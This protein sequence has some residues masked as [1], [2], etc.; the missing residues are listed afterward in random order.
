MTTKISTKD[1]PRDEWLAYRQKSLGGSDAAALLGLS[2]Y[3]SPYSLWAEKTGK[4]IPEDISDRE[5]VRLGNDLEDYVAKRFTEA[6]GK[7]VRRENSI[8]YNPEM[9][10]AHANI[11][12]AVIGEEAG[13]ECKTTISNAIA[14]E[15][16]EGKVPARFYCQVVH[17]LMI[18]GWKRFYLGVL[19]FGRGFYHFVIERDEAEIS[20]LKAAEESFWQKVTTNTP[21]DV[22][23][24]EA[25]L[26]A[27]R[28]IQ[29][30]SRPGMEISLMGVAGELATLAALKKREAELAAEIAEQQARIMG[31]MGGAERGQWGQYKISY[32]TQERRTFDRARF[33]ADHGKIP[34][35]YYKV[36]TSRPLKLSEVKP[37]Q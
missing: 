33:E 22:D 19:V 36:S 24:S 25:T 37:L 10:F 27:I 5:S 28:T 15:C 35:E 9:P 31:Y 20:A 2:D 32:K 23:G 7:K 13:L 29:K 12:R 17:Y 18:T 16:E 34:D 8:I 30:D 14:K 6:T 26:E 4:V 11:D 1:M 3:A 21:P